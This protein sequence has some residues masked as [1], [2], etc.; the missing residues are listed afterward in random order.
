MFQVQEAGHLKKDCPELKKKTEEATGMF[1]G[2]VE[3]WEVDGEEE[4]E[5]LF[6]DAV[7]CFAIMFDCSTFLEGTEGQAEFCQGGIGWHWFEPSISEDD[8]ETVAELWGG[9]EDDSSSEGESILCRCLKGQ[10]G[11]T[12]SEGTSKEDDDEEAYTTEE[13]GQY[14]SLIHI[15]EPTRPY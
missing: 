13:V 8:D 10:S 7:E 1:A 2:M 14:L 12:S 11:D 4:K 15:S 6:G 3:C 5:N 9:K